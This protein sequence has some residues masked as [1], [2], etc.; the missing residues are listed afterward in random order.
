MEGKKLKKAFVLSVGAVLSVA[1]FLAGCGTGMQSSG[2]GSN[3]GKSSSSSSGSSSSS[4]QPQITLTYFGYNSTPANYSSFVNNQI[5]GAF[6]KS[7]PNIKISVDNMANPTQIEQQQMAAGG[8]PDIVMMDGPTNAQDYARA[9]WLVPMD[10]YK[11]QISWLNQVFPWAMNTMYYKGKLMGLPTEYETLVV[12]YNKDMFKQN[13]W[14]IPN[15]F[16]QLIALCKKIQSKGIMPFSFGNSDFKTADEWWLTEAFNEDLGAPAFKK[17]LEGQ[18]PWNSP[19]MVDAVTKLVNMWQAGYINDKK[20]FGITGTDATNLFVQQKAAM[21]MVGTWN[22]P[23]L[24]QDKPSF[25]WSAFEMPAWSSGVTPNFPL[26]IGSAVGIN[27]NSKHPKAAAEFIDWMYSPKLDD[28]QLTQFGTFFPA[29]SV[30]IPS[31]AKVDPHITQQLNALNQA[32]KSNATGYAAW[33]Y[34]PPDV[35]VYLWSN[36]DSVYMGQLSIKT[37]LDKAEQIAL[38]DKQKG[39]LFNFNGK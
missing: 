31:G 2:T 26:A 10:Q 16:D 1:T 17:V 6:E 9:G 23:T 7:H 8:G 24:Q 36:L 14:T 12:Y 32:I 28:D 4:K 37:Y 21:Q 39:K 33:T 20:S 15:N 38:Q 27:K 18:T 25:N 3:S 30:T 11:S 34:W 35:E 29:S 19:Q 22:I 5:I 13:G